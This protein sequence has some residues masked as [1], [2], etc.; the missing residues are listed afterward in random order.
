MLERRFFQLS[1]ALPILVPA[2]L[3]LLP[4]NNIVLIILRVSI[5]LGGLPYILF[6]IPVLVWSRN[7]SGDEIRFFTYFSPLIFGF[8]LAF[9]FGAL[10]LITTLVQPGPFFNFGS[11]QAS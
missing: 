9:C 1:F 3:W 2:I 4:T 11:S 6:I 8:V 5:L 10:T 7:K